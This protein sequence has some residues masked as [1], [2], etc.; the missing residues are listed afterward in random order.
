MKKWAIELRCLELMENELTHFFSACSKSAY[1]YSFMVAQN[2]RTHNHINFE[3]MVLNGNALIK[4]QEDLADQ[5]N[6][7]IGAFEIIND[8]AICLNA[9]NLTV[10]Q[11]KSTLKM[12][13]L[14][15][16]IINQAISQTLNLF[17]LS[18]IT[19][20]S[21]TKINFGSLLLGKNNS[22]NLTK[23]NQEEVYNQIQGL[24]MNIKIDLRNLL[25]K[26]LFEQANEDLCMEAIS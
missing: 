15:E 14:S 22:K 10:S 18:F 24:L 1:A 26:N 25:L 21:P 11:T 12:T 23:Q 4:L 5:L 20:F 2:L 8:E 6:T 9:L 7:S 16:K 3:K 13:V 17:N 19:D